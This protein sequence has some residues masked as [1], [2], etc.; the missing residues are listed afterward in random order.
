MCAARSADELPISRLLGMTGWLS[1]LQRHEN[2]ELRTPQSHGEVG[3]GRRA[4]SDGEEVDNSW[5]QTYVSRIMATSRLFRV[6]SPFRRQVFIVFAV[7]R[8][9]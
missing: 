4:S 9:R 6:L 8:R 7:D 2:V 5:I 3:S 1:T